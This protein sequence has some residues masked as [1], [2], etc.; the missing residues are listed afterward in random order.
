MAVCVTARLSRLSL[1]MCRRYFAVIAGRLWTPA[2]D[3]AAGRLTAIT[4][5]MSPSGRASSWADRARL[6][7][8]TRTRT[9]ESRIDMNPFTV[10]LN[11]HGDLDFFVRAGARGRRIER[12]LG[13]KTSVKDAIEACGVPHPEIDL[14]LVNGQPVDFDYV[15]TGD[16]NIWLFSIAEVPPSF[17]YKRLQNVM[18][19]RFVADVHL[20]AL[21]RN[22]RLLGFDVAYD[23]QA[24]DRQL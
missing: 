19:S 16:T 4:E 18:P 23:P 17:K 6:P 24:E 10:R 15:V 11:L 8:S 5:K 7:S 13:E 21:T 3:C 14:I 9:C 2:A 12:S 20:G 1:L 22:L